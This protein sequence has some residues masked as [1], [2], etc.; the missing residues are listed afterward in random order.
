M[1]RDKEE[2]EE[3]HED[4]EPAPEESGEPKRGPVGKSFDGPNEKR[5]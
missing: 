5:D 3:A 2:A 1:T 4:K